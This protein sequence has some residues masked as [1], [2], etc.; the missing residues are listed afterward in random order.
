[1]KPI[2]SSHTAKQCK[3]ATS[4]NHSKSYIIRGKTVNLLCPKEN[5]YIEITPYEQ[6]PLYDNYANLY[7]ILILLGIFLYITFPHER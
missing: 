7:I 5:C 4:V 1:V 2:Y 6:V 3:Q